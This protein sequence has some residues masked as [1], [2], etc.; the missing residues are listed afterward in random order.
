MT[1]TDILIDKFN[2]CCF[3]LSSDDINHF[4]KNDNGPIYNV[5]AGINK[6]CFGSQIFDDEIG[7]T[8]ELF[9]IN[10][11]NLL[12]G[13][14]IKIDINDKDYYQLLLKFCTL[15]ADDYSEIDAIDS[16]NTFQKQIRGFLEKLGFFTVTNIE[17]KEFKGQ[18]ALILSS[19]KRGIIKL[20]FIEKVSFYK[21]FFHNNCDIE[22]KENSEYVYL[23]VNTDTSLIK[24]GTS[25]DP[26]YREGTLQSKEPSVNLIAKWVL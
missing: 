23:M 15:L 20:R 12:K 7:L 16:F 1:D 21:D 22:T 3:T 8:A 10:N 14:L 19:A 25:K 6:H 2:K 24:I 13:D 4:D 5:I 18:N 11:D 9:Y 26:K 17:L